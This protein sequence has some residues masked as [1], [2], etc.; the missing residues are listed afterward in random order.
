M[1]R[2]SRKTKHFSSWWIIIFLRWTWPFFYPWKRTVYRTVVPNDQ[3]LLAKTTPV[4]LAYIPTWSNTGS[5]IS[6][7]PSRYLRNSTGFVFSVELLIDPVLIPEW[8]LGKIVSTSK[9]SG[10]PITYQFDFGSTQGPIFI[11]QFL[12][13]NVRLFDRVHYVPMWAVQKTYW[14]APAWRRV[15]ATRKK[16]EQFQI[17][18]VDHGKS[19]RRY[20]LQQCRWKT[21]LDIIRKYM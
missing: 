5:N 20:A 16:D 15:F 12:V 2:H 9:K 6:E 18:S 17:S 13:G 4:R 10:V 19:I 3:F 14:W 11:T 8:Y 1:Y 7:V 21:S